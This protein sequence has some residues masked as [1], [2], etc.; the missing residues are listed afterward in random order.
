MVKTIRESGI[1]RQKNP[2]QNLSNEGFGA[3]GKNA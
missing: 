3:F 1:E 2:S